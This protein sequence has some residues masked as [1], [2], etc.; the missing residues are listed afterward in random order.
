MV[1]RTR[2][3]AKWGFRRIPGKPAKFPWGR[4]LHR[5]TGRAAPRTAGI[6][7]GAVEIFLR[8]TP[9]L[10]GAQ[11]PALPAQVGGFLISLTI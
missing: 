1:C 10:R 6:Y 3:P 9:R 11:N 5:G 2:P 7:L 8:N 4:A